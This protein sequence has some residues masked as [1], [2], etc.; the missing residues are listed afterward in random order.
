MQ[1]NAGHVVGAILG[2]EAVRS[3]DFAH[4]RAGRHLDPERLLDGLVL[5]LGRVLQID[6]DAGRKIAG[7]VAGL[8]LAAGGV[9]DRYHRR[10]SPQPCVSSLRACLRNA[11]IRGDPFHDVSA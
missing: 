9:I 3:L 6:P 7:F 2:I 4:F 5:V 1:D 8:Q 10:T 11:D